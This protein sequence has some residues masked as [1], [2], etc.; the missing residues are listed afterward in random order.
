MDN[1]FDFIIVGAG[2]AGMAAAQYAARSGLKT[3]LLDAGFPGGQVAM[4]FNLENYPGFFPAANGFEF[5][6]KMKDQAVAFGANILQA[7]VSSIDK[8]QNEYSIKTSAG[9]FTAPAVL[10][11]TGADHRKLGIPGEKE[12]FGRGVSYCATC[13]GPFFRNKKIVVVGG[14]DS[15]CD[16]ATYLSTI[17]QVTI[18]HRKASF[19]AQKAV[20][21]RVLSNPAITVKFNSSVTAVFGEAKVSSVELTDTVTGEKSVL[22]TDAVFV[23]VGM[24][25]RTELLSNLKTD[26]AGYIITNE[27]METSVPGLYAAG[28]VR[29]KSF[30]QVVTACAD[31]AIA[32]NSAQKFIRKMRGEEY[33]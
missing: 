9:T 10:L 4:I 6:A 29:S 23:S 32:A 31:G 14:G 13:D 26:D 1:N 11:A 19:R 5:I 27:D 7:Q 12:F 20:A 15:A 8:I 18:V 17:G 24:L 21:Q 30:R 25:P 3:L 16:E 22:E 2:P 28:D 33:K